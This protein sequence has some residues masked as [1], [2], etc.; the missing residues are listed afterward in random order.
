MICNTIKLRLAFDGGVGALV[1]AAVVGCSDDARIIES[2]PSPLAAGPLYA[3]SSRVLSPETESL[4]V[5]L[6]PSLDSGEVNLESAIEFPGGAS[7]FGKPETGVVYV[8]PYTSPTIERWTLTDQGSLAPG[9]VVSFANLGLESAATGQVFSQ[10]RGYFLANG[11]IVMWDPENMEL[12]DTFP[13]PELEYTGEG[14][15]APNASIVALG[16][17]SILVFGHWSDVDEWNRWAD[18]ST[19]VV[20]DTVTNQVVSAWDEPRSEMLE[21]YG[22]RTTDG[23]T[24]FSSDP[25]Y[26]TDAFTLGDDYGSRPVTLRMLEGASAFDPNFFVDVSTLVGGRPAGIVTPVSDDTFFID[27]L[28]TELL[29]KPLEDPTWSENPPAAYRYWLWHVGDPVATD[30]VAQEPRLA[31]TAFQSIID[32]KVYVQG[33]DAKFGQWW[34]IE[35]RPD[36]TLSQGLAGPGYSAELVRVR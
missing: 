15:Y 33:H 16:D 27:V 22:K 32:G 36:G 10:G 25:A 14:E 18:H 21:P 1:L 20:F 9:D 13:I 17:E 8:A 26:Q 24:Y 6:L 5:S 30:T 23:A 28:H 12:L 19:Q 7:L 3:V 31:S 2:V 35:L 4:Y 34:L 29:D 11:E